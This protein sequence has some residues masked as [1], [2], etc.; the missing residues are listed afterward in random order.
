MSGMTFEAL[1]APRLR[2]ISFGAGVQST[3]ML[4]MACRG[5]IGPRPRAAIFADTGFEPAAIYA[6]LEWCRAEV[7][8]LTNGQ[9][10]IHVV[11]AGNIR[12]DHIEGKNTTGGKFSSMPLYRADG[13]RGRRQCTKEYKVRPIIREI[14]R[15]AGVKPKYPFPRGELVEQWIGISTDEI[16][17]CKAPEPKWLVSRYPLIERAMNRADCRAW[18]AR[19]YPG[20]PLVKSA[21]IACPF[22]RN[23]DWRQLKAAD[24]KS[25]AEA[26]E[27][28]EAI[29]DRGAG[30]AEQFV[31]RDGRPL[32]EADLGD[33]ATLDMFAGECEGMCGA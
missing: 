4:L 15:L 5:E 14:R 27:F 29:R 9:I 26:I 2:V 7:A 31:H 23:I 12:E 11:S 8:R 21:C 19:E 24:P 13:G 6:H 28:D 1:E 10:P 32:A 22:R 18:F 3:A 33:E 17:R 16:Q 25:W 30:G 20:Q